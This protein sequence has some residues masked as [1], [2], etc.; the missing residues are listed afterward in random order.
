MLSDKKRY[1]RPRVHAV[2]CEC[3]LMD[4]GSVEGVTGGNSS[5][6]NGGEGSDGDEVDAKKHSFNVWDVWDED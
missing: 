3:F 5:I 1:V 4:N 2:H 6:Q